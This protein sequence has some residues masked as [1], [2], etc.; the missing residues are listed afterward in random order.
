MGTIE[1]TLSVGR[2]WKRQ[3]V[4]AGLA[5][6]VALI[7]FAGFFALL[8][9]FFP[10]G[11]GIGQLLSSDSN[12]E[13]ES[14]AQD[15][16]RMYADGLPLDSVVGKLIARKNDVRAKAMDSVVWTSATL[17]MPL[18]NRESVQTLDRAVA[19]IELQ[20]DD[21]IE[22]GPNTLIVLKDLEEDI[23]SRRQRSSL[24]VLDGALRG[25][26]SADGSDRVRLEVPAGDGTATIQPMADEGGEVVFRVDVS[27]E[28]TAT[29]TVEKG[30]AEIRSGEDLVTVRE[31][32][33][34]RL[35]D[36]SVPPSVIRLRPGP[37]L[38]MP[39][40][41]Q[42]F[43][44]RKL[45]PEVALG[46]TQ[47]T[48]VTTYR[49]RVARDPGFA[50]MVY[51]EWVDGNG[52]VLPSLPAGTYHW[53]VVGE[54]D[55]AEVT[56]RVQSQFRVSRDAT[57]PPLRLQLPEGNVTSEVIVIEGQVEPGSR[58]RVAGVTVELDR[59]GWFSHEVSLD[60]GPNVLVVEAID[61][62]GNVAYRS[63]VVNRRRLR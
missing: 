36:S 44:Y 43:E 31:N 28:Q 23:F 60:F 1:H 54:S 9:I 17:G 24:L 41:G 48:G 6:G 50:E 35:T 47:I 19:T 32:Q 26:L 29:V 12:A 4:E 3:V 42:R 51:D 18:K 20:S 37:E 14:R 39:L 40:P 45:Q 34:T 15:N 13:A 22:M 59:K 16:R 27:D 61:P 38:L 33:S 62:A 58:V 10:T 11:A 2:S 55:R 52:V 8:E 7:F 25:R 63:S 53:S 56:A 5:I 49:L 57:P 21:E 30:R 46:W